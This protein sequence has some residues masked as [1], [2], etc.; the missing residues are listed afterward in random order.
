VV[1]RTGPDGVAVVPDPDRRAA[2]RGA[3][4]HP[5]LACF[6]QAVRRR[7]FGR[8]LRVTVALDTEPGRRHLEGQSQAEPS[9]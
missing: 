5:T 1:I 9:T 2:G 7:A 6:E 4:L 3:S 8:A